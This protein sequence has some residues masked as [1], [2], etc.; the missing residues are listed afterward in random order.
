MNDIINIENF[1]KIVVLSKPKFYDWFLK[2]DKNI[3]LSDN[4]NE[5]F[6]KKNNILISCCTNIILP[7][8]YFSKYLIA[9][10]I[11]PASFDYPGR[12]PHHWA[13]YH[14]CKNYGATAHLLSEKV[15][16]GLIID[17]ELIKINILATANM[18]Y[19]IGNKCAQ[20]LIARIIKGINKKKLITRNAKWKGK[21]N[22]RT[23]LL[24]MCNFKNLEID[25]ID[26]RKFSFKGFEKFFT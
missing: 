18:Y 3:V 21:S 15:D 1:E 16:Q 23:D 4:I 2:V 22:K 19:E 8:N 7:K 11:H 10:N 14:Q 17:Y 26:R 12:D 6:A 5:A 13:C 24:K 9:I 20:L 25:E